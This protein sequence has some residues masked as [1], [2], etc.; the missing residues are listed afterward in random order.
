MSFWEIARTIF[1]YALIINIILACLLVF[2]ERKHP[3]VTL[4]WILALLFIPVLGF[5]LYIFLGQDLRKEKIFYLKESEEQDFY[6]LIEN[7]KEGM[8]TSYPPFDDVDLD[9]YYDMIM[10]NLNSS[11]SLFSRDNS[12]DLYYEGESHFEDL[13]ASINAA[14]DFIHLQT[15]I[16]RNDSLG[17]GLI[18]LLT[19]KARQG[20]EVK[21]L[22]DGMGCIRLPRRF[23]NPLVEAGGHIAEFFPPLL[24][25]INL[26]INYRNHRKICI[27]DGQEAWVGGFNVGDEYRGRSRRFGFW[28]DTHARIRGS[29]IGGL[30]F[31]FLLDWRFA[32]GDDHILNQERLIRYFTLCEGSGKAGVQI[33]SSGPDSSWPAVKH[34]YLKMITL[35]TEK[36]YISTPY[37][38]PD[39][40]ILEALKISALSGVDTRV[41]I[42]AVS[43]H[44][45]VHWASQYYAGELL[46]A[47]VQI[48][49][50]EKGFVHSKTIVVDNYISTVG[51]ANL[52]IRSFKLNFEVN[53]FIYDREV[54]RSL[55][56]AFL[57]DLE[58]SQE[59]TMEQYE[60]RSWGAKIK[61]GF[62]RL[63]SPLL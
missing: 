12:I 14:Q 28:R 37:L 46:E 38:I 5:V 45:F 29:A 9:F 34:A 10:L 56:Q 47:G 16:I 62:T 53:A 58:S 7:Q 26:R 6:P 11:Q 51:T 24:P 49:L 8:Q 61:E 30:E 63:L 50:Y 43:D 23:F 15:Y 54:A 39:S 60:N 57:K 59:M 31:R 35:A 22:Y 21:L 42:P 1:D 36:V 48:F 40:S 19:E 3:T 55:E 17:K 41:L 33:V 4:T 18:G 13:F 52:D 25:Y 2:F 32:A 44:P 27:I 20:V